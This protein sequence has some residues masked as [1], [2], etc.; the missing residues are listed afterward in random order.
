MNKRDFILP[1]VGV[2]VGVVNLIV[3]NVLLGII[4][5]V[6]SGIHLGALI[7]EHHT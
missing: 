4:V 1:T 7:N 6:A 5:C 3:G 2:V